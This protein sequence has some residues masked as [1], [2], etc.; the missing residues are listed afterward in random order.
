M[1]IV[2]WRSLLVECLAGWLGGRLVGYGL[3]YLFADWLELFQ[4][5]FI[6]SLIG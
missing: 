4:E 6:C 5:L 3:I 2:G 1:I